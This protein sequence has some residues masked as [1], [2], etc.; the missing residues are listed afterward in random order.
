MDSIN[1][2]DKCFQYAATVALNHG[3]IGKNSQRIWKIKLFI[4][5]KKW[6]GI[7]YPSGKV[8]WKKFEKNNSTI[9]LNM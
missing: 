7:N 1:D 6:K 2:C 8:D 5:K 4:N 9:I 3:K